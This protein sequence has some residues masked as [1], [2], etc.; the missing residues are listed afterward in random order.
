MPVSNKYKA[1]FVHIPKNAGESIEKTLEMYGGNPNETLWGVLGNRIVLQ[2][3]SATAM[4]LFLKNDEL[5]KIYFKFAVVRNPWSKAV[6]EYNWYLRYGP[7]CSFKEWV[8]SLRHRIMINDLIH[9]REIGH[10]IPQYK[11]VHNANG[12]CLVDQ[13]LRF[14][15]LNRDFEKLATDCNWDVKLRYED[16]T[17]SS[18][19]R[20]FREYYDA[21]CIDEIERLYYKDIEIFGYSKQNTF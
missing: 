15:N 7:K 10:N 1:I 2:H 18:K 13:V 17:K 4:K 6:S 9:R 16:T 8:F 11:F 12:E 5:W 21:D 20:D 19:S 14:E 3:F